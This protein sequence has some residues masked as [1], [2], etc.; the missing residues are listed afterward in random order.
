MTAALRRTYSIDE[1]YAIERSMKSKEGTSDVQTELSYFYN[2]SR[3]VPVNKVQ[4]QKTRSVASKDHETFEIGM[5]YE[6]NQRQKSEKKALNQSQSETHPVNEVDA[7]FSGT[8]EEITKGVQ[9]ASLKSFAKEKDTIED[10][11]NGDVPYS[12]VFEGS[13]ETMSPKQLSHREP[14]SNT[15]SPL[16]AETKSA[17]QEFVIYSSI[18]NLPGRVPK[19]DAG[20]SPKLLSEESVNATHKHDSNP[21]KS[22]QNLSFT[23]A[24][25]N[26]STYRKEGDR[27]TPDASRLCNEEQVQKSMTKAANSTTGTPAGIPLYQQNSKKTGGFNV[28]MLNTLLKK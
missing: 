9:D 12:N 14:F 22:R 27:T 21:P 4:L 5:Q 17:V 20:K 8:L 1:M 7:L 10:R 24:I 3:G 18:R 2:P 15:A 19:P 23:Q 28:S 25:K 13:S 6:A 16:T 26:S 11:L